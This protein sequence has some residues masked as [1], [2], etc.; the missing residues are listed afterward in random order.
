MTARHI[1][2]RGFSAGSSAWSEVTSGPL[3]GLTI[4]G[5]TPGVVWLHGIGSSCASDAA[6]G[7]ESL[8]DPMRLGRTIL[9]LDQRGHGRSSSCHDSS[10]GFEQYT[11]AE[12]GKELRIASRA[13]LSRAFF[14]GEGTGGAAAL[15]A[16]ASAAASGSVDTPPGLILVRPSACMVP[17][18]TGEEARRSCAALAKELGESNSWDKFLAAEAAAAYT[19]FLDCR[20]SLGYGSKTEF[21]GEALRNLRQSTIDIAVLR[22]ALHGL[23]RS[24]S[25]EGDAARSLGQERHQSM[26]QDAYGVDFT[27][28]CPVQIFGLEDDPELDRIAAQELSEL[29]PD[30]SISW[31]ASGEEALEEWP[32]VIASF[33]RKAWLKE[34]M[35]KRVMPQ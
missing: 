24:S 7:V 23:E 26:A 30:A 14:A 4:I 16:A 13:S 12:L 8:L 31:A 19:P 6:R 22:S 27:L 1:F 11:S 21:D 34:F 15:S 10:I 5:P 18:P 3:S 29:L 17:G 20:T 33:L 9:R 25:V 28:S 35:Q 2:T 32:K